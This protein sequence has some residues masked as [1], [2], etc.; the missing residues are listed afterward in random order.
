MRSSWILGANSSVKDE[1]IG[2]EQSAVAD[3]TD[4]GVDRELGGRQ[5]AFLGP[6]IVGVEPEAL[7]Q[8]QPA[9]DAA[10]LVAGAVMVE[11]PHLPFAAEP[12]SSQREMSAA[13]FIGMRLW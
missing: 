10:L 6:D 9:H 13:S 1:A 3:E 11:Q 8:A 2:L 12:A 7:A 5:D 4:I